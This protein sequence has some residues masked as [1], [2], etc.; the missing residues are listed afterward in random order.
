MRCLGQQGRSGSSARAL[1]C[2]AAIVSDSV[3]IRKTAKSDS[4]LDISIN[5]PP[6]VLL[7]ADY[8]RW[9]DDALQKHGM[10]PGR[11]H[12]EILESAEFDDDKRRDAAVQ[13]LTDLG[14]R[15]VMDDLGSGYSSLLRLRTLPFHAVKIDQGLV[16]EAH[17]DPR[18]IIG[19]IGALVRLGKGLGLT[20]A[21]EGLETP[22]LIEAAAVLGADGGQGYA[23]AKPMPASELP[24]W[25]RHFRLSIDPSSPRTPLGAV[26]A[27]WLREQTV[28]IPQSPSGDLARRCDAAA[29]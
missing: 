25:V 18:R 9:I 13:M 28:F 16:R 8:P 15:L 11:L 7:D 19:F 14:V 27:D 22:D 24:D 10:A 3:F 21:V 12:L 2:A 29:T 6:E 4:L 26:A 23:L 5:L 1:G 17:K 20:V